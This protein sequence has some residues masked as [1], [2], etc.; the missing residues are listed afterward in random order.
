MKVPRTVFLYGGEE[1]QP[2]SV[3]AISDYLRSMFRGVKIVNRDN[4][5][6]YFN[7]NDNGDIK[8]LARS[9]ASLKIRDLNKVE[10][11]FQPLL[12]EISYEGR[13]LKGEINVTG[14]ILYDGP[15]LAILFNSLIP[16]KEQHRDFLHIIFTN[17]LFGTFDKDDRRYHARVVLCAFPS[18]ISLSG[19]VEAPA[20]PKEFYRLKQMYQSSGTDMPVEVIKEKFEGR[21]IDYDDERTTEAIKGYVLQAIFHHIGLRPFCDDPKCRLFNAHWQSEVIS[22]QLTDPEFCDKHQKIM[23][24]FG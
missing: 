18:I 17:R 8:N 24:G 23:E 22:A 4:I 5:I 14:G 10:C 3:E 16:K 9:L 6:S 21:F 12:G 7:C 13:V 11:D 15:G 2:L 1:V 19:L 20:K